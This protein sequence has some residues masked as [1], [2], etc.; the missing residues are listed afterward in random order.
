MWLWQVKVSLE[1]LSDLVISILIDHT[2]N[3]FQGLRHSHAVNDVALTG[4]CDNLFVHIR[5]IVHLLVW[6]FLFLEQTLAVDVFRV[7]G[8]SSV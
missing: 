6:L 4:V 7:P 5:S 8:E 2:F 3:N 1:V